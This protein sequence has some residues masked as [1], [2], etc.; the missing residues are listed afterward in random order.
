MGDNVGD[1]DGTSRAPLISLPC[2][3]LHYH[4]LLCLALLCL[5]FGILF[6]EIMHNLPFVFNDGDIA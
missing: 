3:T 2:T 1:D 6:R 4:A 5:Y